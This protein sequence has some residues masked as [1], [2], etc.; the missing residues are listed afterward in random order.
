VVTVLEERVTEEH[1]SVVHFY[2]QKDSV[3]RIFI[4]KCFLFIIRSV[5][6]VKVF[7]SG[8]RLC[9]LGGKRLADDI[10][11]EM[12]VQK[13]LRQQPNVFYAAGFDVLVKQWEKCINVSGGYVKK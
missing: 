6:Q 4:K 3:Q 5:C 8:P 13:W 1:H 7:T 10:E 9:H 11:V 2:G 12:K